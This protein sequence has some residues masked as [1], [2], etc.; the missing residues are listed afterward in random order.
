M[1]ALLEFDLPEEYGDFRAHLDGPNALS[2]LWTVD[3]RLR[4]LIKH[5]ELSAAAEDALQDVRDF[6]RECCTSSNVSLDV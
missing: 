2:V 3:Q 5:G 6:L 1:K 4:S